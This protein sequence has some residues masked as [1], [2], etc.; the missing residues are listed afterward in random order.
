MSGSSPSCTVSCTQVKL[1]QHLASGAA[2]EVWRGSIAPHTEEVA[3]KVVRCDAALDESLVAD[4]AREIETSWFLAQGCTLIVKCT[5]FSVNPPY[6]SVVMELCAQGSLLSVLGER[7]G[8]GP[9]DYATR[10]HYGE[11]TAQ[12][13]AHMHALQMVHRDLKS[14]NVFVTHDGQVRLGDFGES[15]TLD[16]AESEHPAKV[17][18]TTQ[19]MAPEI[20][21]N[22]RAGRNGDSG[23]AYSCAADT[24]SLAV[25]AWECITAS[26]PYEGARHHGRALFGAYLADAVTERGVRVHDFAGPAELQNA[27]GAAVAAGVA[28]MLQQAWSADPLR[29]PSALEIA[30]V[31][32][33]EVRNNAVQSRSVV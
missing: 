19:W 32:D 24:F 33:Q 4:T 17:V 21:N 31:L 16:Q 28:E 11:Q 20:I 23:T 9:P 8:R 6:L 25:V 14:L 26:L 22:W 12:A 15:V 10:L 7:A 18:G 1:T 5:G 3:I 30:G 27:E 13:V 29:R 2:G